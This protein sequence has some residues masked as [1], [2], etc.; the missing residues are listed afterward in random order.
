MSENRGIGSHLG[1]RLASIDATSVVAT[2][3][4]PNRE[5]LLILIEDFHRKVSELNVSV[6]VRLLAANYMNVVRLF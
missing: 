6:R 3:Q 4:G 5:L 2:G 1:K